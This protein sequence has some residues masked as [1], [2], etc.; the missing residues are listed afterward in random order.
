[1]KH[2]SQLFSL[3]IILVFTGCTKEQ[4]NIKPE[5]IIDPE[6][7]S[8]VSFLKANFPEKVTALHIENIKTIRYHKQNVGYQIFEKSDSKKF[9]VLKKEGPTYSGNWVDLNAMSINK[10]N[11]FS[12]KI[13]LNGLR[14]ESKTDLIIEN[15]KVIQVEKWDKTLSR[16]IVGYPRQ[17]GISTQNGISK[18]GNT[19]LQD[20]VVLQEVVIVVN[21]AN[22]WNL[23]WLFNE[24]PPFSYSYYKWDTDS[25][26]SGGGGGNGNSSPN[27]QNDNVIGLPVYE[28]PKTPIKDLKDELK[29]LTIN[30]N[31]TYSISIN[32]NQPRPDSRDKVDPSNN[33]MAGHTFLT[34]EQNN[35][36]GSKIIR[37]VGF[38]P[39]NSVYPGNY[40][41]QSIFG[42]DSETP[43]AV[44][45]KIAVTGQEM[46]T[47]VKSLLAQQS[48]SYDLENSNCVSSVALSLQK[49]NIQLPMT[50]TGIEYLFKGVNP[51]DFGQD[52]RNLDLNNFRKENG[53]RT[54]ERITSKKND[55]RPS[56]KNGSC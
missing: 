27:N 37:N 51:G 53:D 55:L 38:Y 19:N 17:R 42:E 25:E 46:N 14:N 23:Y 18:T 26:F 28:G 49:I 4:S 45:L 15:N 47:V 29:C 36:D 5:K 12:G 41:D 2:F 22:Y 34:L 21:R 8:V 35:A 44:S 32:V 16:K 48:L 3:V 7:D 24:Y 43:F 30:P 56:G 31:S 52:I 1:M 54:V 50:S 11:S 20:V 39:K 6:I 40:E 10:S 9:L 33:F 13:Q